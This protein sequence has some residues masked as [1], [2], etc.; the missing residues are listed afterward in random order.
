MEMT[1]GTVSSI[2]PITFR[3][4]YPSLRISFTGTPALHP[5]E[6]NPMS[7]NSLLAAPFPSWEEKPTLSTLRTTIIDEV[8]AINRTVLSKSRALQRMLTFVVDST[9]DGNA[10]NIK[11]YTIATLV[12]GK[13]QDFDPRMT[14]LVRTQ[15]HKLR[16]ALIKYYGSRRGIDGPWIWIP[17]GSYSAVFNVNPGMYF[18]GGNTTAA[19]EE[20]KVSPPDIYVA[21]PAVVARASDLQVL[22]KEVRRLQRE[23]SGLSRL[24]LVLNASA[25]S[26]GASRRIAGALIE[27]I[28]YEVKHTIVEL[29]GR[30]LVTA[31]LMTGQPPVVLVGY[32][33]SVDWA[34]D[35][36][37]TVSCIGPFL[38]VF[39][40][41]CWSLMSEE[42]ITLHRTT[43]SLTPELR[44]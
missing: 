17:P 11:E 20:P 23:H 19:R 41:K 31:C 35:E 27:P 22:S 30:L 18:N 13:H 6:A 36:A 32:S 25:Y 38:S 43:V 42:V 3:G 9:L 10:D 28:R 12:F 26:L 5:N 29:D 37:K 24:I 2:G 14:S 8:E 21:E 33:F 4:D 40:D 7:Q 15:A 39:V 16:I 1:G 44:E 34:G